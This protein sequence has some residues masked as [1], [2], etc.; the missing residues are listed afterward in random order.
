M[1]AVLA[2]AAV[3][4]LLT[5]LVTA[6][7]AM[8][9]SCGKEVVNDWYDNGRVDKIYPLA[10]YREAIRILPTD[11]IDYSNAKEEIGRALAYAK[12]GQ[13]DPGSKPAGTSTTPTATTPTTSTPTATTPQATTGSATTTSQTVTTPKPGTTGSATPP[14]TEAGGSVDTSGPSSVPVPLIVLG[15]LAVLLLAAGS[16]GYL[17]R[18]AA[19]LC[20]SPTTRYTAPTGQG[21]RFPQFPGISPLFSGSAVSSDRPPSMP[22]PLANALDA[23]GR[24][25]QMSWTAREEENGHRQGSTHSP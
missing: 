4:A 7:P 19:G 8:A 10:C 1:L 2:A 24:E 20:L 18:S 14:L 13:G 15:G 23:P 12:Q 21:G 22:G 5:V 9:A 25:A 11:V 6:A 16:A 3:A 17:A